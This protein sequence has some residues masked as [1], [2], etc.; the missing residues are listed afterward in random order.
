LAKVEA[1]V[2]PT[3]AVL[4]WLDEAQ[5]HGTMG[6]YLTSIFSGSLMPTPM[7]TV[8]NAA[9]AGAREANKGQPRDVVEK[10]A[11]AAAR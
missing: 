1:S 4:R 6:G 5:S 8:M 3:Q 11:T 10:A 2:T 9:I 7:D